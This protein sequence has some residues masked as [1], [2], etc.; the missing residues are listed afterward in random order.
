MKHSSKRRPTPK[1]LRAVQTSRHLRVVQHQHTGHLTHRRT[2]SYPTLVMIVLC[3]GVFLAS[4]TRFVGADSFIYPGPVTNSYVVHASVPGPAPTIAPTIESP[5]DGARFVDQPI[6]LSGSC[7][8]N[9]YVTVYR[10]GAFSGV[11]LCEAGGTWHLQTALFA[12]VNRLQARVFSSTDVPGP[13]SGLVTVTYTPP[14]S[15]T[16]PTS[17]PAG[18][19]SGNSY[20]NDSGPTSAGTSSPPVANHRSTT[21]ASGPVVQGEPLIFKTSFVYEGHYVGTAS[22]WQLAIE[23]GTAPYAISVD[24]GDGKH[25]LISRQQAGPFTMEH[26]YQ[27]TGGYRGSYAPKFTASDAANNQTFLQ[28][29][30]IVN[31]PPAGAGSGHKG[32]QATLIGGSSMSQDV[33]K[34]LKYIWPGY[35][36]VVLMLASFW[37]GERREYRS[38]KPRLKKARHA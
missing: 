27:K 1:K 3:V 24:W 35:G 18:G 21:N 26:I 37:L 32:I 33:S 17:T 6:E 4:W 16:P 7:P 11:A 13:L 10:N 14:L 29:L 31:N 38:L 34:L 36:M 28:L 19:T 5:A 12:G 22:S 23:G 20:P 25:S 15:P 9:S 30:A 8:T 2:T